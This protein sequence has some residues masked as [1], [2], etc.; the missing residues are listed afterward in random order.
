[1]SCRRAVPQRL[2]CCTRYGHV[3]EVQFLTPLSREDTMPS[4]SGQRCLEQRV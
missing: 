1:M 3:V 4:V 2:R